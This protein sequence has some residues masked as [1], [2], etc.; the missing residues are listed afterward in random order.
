MSHLENLLKHGHPGLTSRPSVSS[1]WRWD[2]EIC[3]FNKLPD[4]VDAP[5]P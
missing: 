2:P 4:D 5:G 3:F 1:G